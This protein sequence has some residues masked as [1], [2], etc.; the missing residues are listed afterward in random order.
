LATFALGTAA[1]DWT[2]SNLKLGYLV[3]AIVFLVMMAIPAVG[4][5]KF[6]LN[7]I[8]SFWCAYVIT[9]PVGASFADW[10][11]ASPKRHGLGFG[12]GPVTLVATV[13]IV[14]LVGYLAVSERQLESAPETPEEQPANR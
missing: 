6:G 8:L 9:R 7:P 11:G 10:F 3:S 13:I 2:A 5:W 4:H 12:T 14:G 1:G